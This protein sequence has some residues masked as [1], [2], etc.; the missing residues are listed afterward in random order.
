MT[1]RIGGSD[2]RNT[3]TSATYSPTPEMSVPQAQA[4]YR[5]SEEQPLGPWLVNGFEWFSSATDANMAILLAKT[6]IGGI[7]AF[8]APMRR[9][10][11]HKLEAEDLSL[12]P[13]ELNGITIQRLKAKLGTRALPTA[14]HSLSDTRAY[15]LGQEGQGVKEM[16]TIL[17]ITRI[18][19]AITACGLLGRGL[20][21]SR[22]FARVRSIRLV[23]LMD[24]PAHIRTMATVHIEYRASMLLVFFVVAL[25]GVSELPD[26]AQTMS[27][28]YQCSSGSSGLIPKS[29]K[30]ALLLLRVLTP[31]VKALTAKSAIAGLAECMESLVGVGYL[32]SSSPLDIGT[33]IARLYRDAN[34]LSIWEGT[35]DV[36]ADDVIRVLKGKHGI[37]VITELDKWVCDLTQCS[38]ESICEGRSCETIRQFWSNWMRRVSSRGSDEW[39]TIGRDIMEGL[40]W[41]MSAILLKEDAR[42]DNDDDANCCQ[43]DQER[44]NW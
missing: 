37:E 33:N 22:A 16:S 26:D 42:R 15:L 24:I 4:A 14:E 11:P 6:K 35:T 41:T 12:V 28:P 21:I 32:D 7:S 44:Y 3:E 36:M 20:A 40:G 25:L 38:P 30:T 23:K 13:T 19:N 31:V 17:N 1:E 27:P 2:V 8:F 29:S 18:H 39:N 10:V 43:V 34:V 9:T 5:F